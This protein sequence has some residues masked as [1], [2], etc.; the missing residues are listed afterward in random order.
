MNTEDQTH[1]NASECGSV[2]FVRY[3]KPQSLRDHA[4]VRS[5]EHHSF[6]A[7]IHNEGSTEQACVDPSRSLLS[8]GITHL[9]HGE[10]YKTLAITK[11]LSVPYQ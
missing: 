9:S 8:I 10:K 5:H 2:V 3:L 4:D 7:V 11:A 1:S 6:T